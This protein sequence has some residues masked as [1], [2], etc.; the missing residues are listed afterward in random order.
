[1]IPDRFTTTKQSFKLS[2][3]TDIRYMHKQ[4]KIPKRNNSLHQPLKTGHLLPLPGLQPSFDT[5]RKYIPKFPTLIFCFLPC[6][7]G[8]QIVRKFPT[9]SFSSRSK[10]RPIVPCNLSQT[11][12]VWMWL[13]LYA[14]VCE[15]NHTNLKKKKKK[16]NPKQNKTKNKTNKN[17]QQQQQQ[18]NPN[19][20]T[21]TTNVEYRGHAFRAKIS[22]A[23]R[24]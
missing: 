23:I 11:K 24:F 5:C 7:R 13:M 1:M 17:K 16:K 19:P 20:T 9:V 6:S 4:T 21:T 12:K 8:R 14:L 22:I 3:L 10:G 15:H 18:K 2:K